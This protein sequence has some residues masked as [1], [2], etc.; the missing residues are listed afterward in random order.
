MT[1]ATG[2]GHRGDCV[3]ISGAAGYSTTKCSAV[4][5]AIPATMPSVGE[6]LQPTKMPMPALLS[7]IHTHRAGS[8][9][10]ALSGSTFL[11]LTMLMQLPFMRRVGTRGGPLAPTTGR[12]FCLEA[13][14]SDGK[15]VRFELGYQT[16]PTNSA[17]T[18]SSACRGGE[19][20][21]TGMLRVRGGGVTFSAGH[22]LTGVLTGG[23]AIMLPRHVRRVRSRR[24]SQRRHGVHR[25]RP[26]RRGP[27]TPSP[28]RS[29]QFSGDQGCDLL[30]GS[31][32]FTA[33]VPRWP[34]GLSEQCLL[35]VVVRRR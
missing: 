34:V 5:V 12:R 1:E 18:T 32:L 9:W 22:G 10:G 27:G 4:R 33:S 13:D 21:L 24:G 23:T 16:I 11:V 31:P 6:L 19:P 35:C 7:R 20:M 8:R 28:R 3:C 25:T 2:R 17:Y 26:D 29:V 15:S 14:A 30:R